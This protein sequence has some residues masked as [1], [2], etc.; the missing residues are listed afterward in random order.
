M[1]F[2][3]GRHDGFFSLTPLGRG[4]ASSTP[5]CT[6]AGMFEGFQGRG[7]LQKGGGRRFSDGLLQKFLLELRYRDP[8]AWNSL[9]FKG[10]GG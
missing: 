2:V 8:F 1:L 7:G 10:E 5:W 6:N 4:V 3:I 9:I